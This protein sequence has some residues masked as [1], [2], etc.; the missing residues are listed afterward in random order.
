M[1]GSCIDSFYRIVCFTTCSQFKRMDI[2]LPLHINELPNGWCEYPF[3]LTGY[4]VDYSWKAAT[5]SVFNRKHNEFWMIWSDIFP[6]IVF[7]YLYFVNRASESFQKRS[8]FLQCLVVGLYAAVILSRMCS[9]FYHIYNCVSLDM[10]QRLINLDLIGICFMAL[11]SPWIFAIANKSDRFGDPSFLAYIAVLLSS[12][13]GCIILLCL[14]FTGNVSG[15]WTR[16]R[17]P[18]LVILSIIG[19]FPAIQVGTDRGFSPVWR[20]LSLLAVGGFLLGYAVFFAGRFPECLL[21]LGVADGKVWNSHVIWHIIASLAQLFYV[22]T[23]FL[24]VDGE[25]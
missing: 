16:V 20:S 9:C 2:P 11:G 14:L 1:V 8:L 5:L 3:T 13:C 7:E 23:T 24:P 25:I 17:Q 21:P 10:N 4:R 18:C 6:I 22:M 15:G 12:F 19:N